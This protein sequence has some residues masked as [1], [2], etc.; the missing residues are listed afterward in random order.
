M[1]LFSLSLVA[2]ET[3]TPDVFLSEESNTTNTTETSTAE[4]VTTE[5]Q[6]NETTETSPAE[7]ITNATTVSEEQTNTTN[8]S[9]TSTAENATTETNTAVN[10]TNETETT[11]SVQSI[12][13]EKIT[14]GQI[15]VGEQQLNIVL[16][17]TGNV[18]LYQLEAEV[19][20]YGITTKEKIAIEELPA[21][22]KDYTF[23]KITAEQI[24]VIDLIIKVYTNGTL[25]VQQIS[26]IE[27]VGSPEEVT[28]Q[29]N[30][31]V[32]DVA[33]ASQILNETKNAYADLEKEFYQKQKEEYV[34]YGIH[35]DLSETK[36]YL[37]QAQVALIEQNQREFDKNVAAAKTNLESLANELQNA[38]KE[39]K[40]WG[41]II[42]ENLA[43]IGSLL[44]VFISAVTVWSM[45]KAHLKNTRVINIIKGKQILNVDKDTKV[46]NR[47][48]E[49]KEEKKEDKKEEK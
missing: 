25:L 9:E 44:G 19:T 24:G 6:L 30:E 34:L 37:R 23:T 2:Q 18:P 13:L 1:S 28:E 47:I 46:E 7:E 4:N 41:Q 40:K 48:Q 5:M 32:M 29:V 42:L 45:T 3:N 26:S 36:E 16:K 38:Q 31:T 27:V 14:P 35:D 20:G 49:T 12:S 43:L 22:E 39:Q 17:N 10:T 33:A 21:G 15:S 11:A 8:A